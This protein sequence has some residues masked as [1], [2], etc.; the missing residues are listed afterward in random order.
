[1]TILAG[2]PLHPLVVHAAV[3]L[4]PL[5]ALGVVLIAVF[6]KLRRHYSTL[7][8]LLSG[9][10]LL[11]MPIAS[12]TGEDL[13]RYVD[14]TQAMKDHVAMGESGSVAAVAVLVAAC[15]LWWMER[16][17]RRSR[18]TLGKFIV[19]MSVL[20]AIAATAQIV[21]IGHSGATS[22]WAKESV[23]QPHTGWGGEGE[24]GE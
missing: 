7:V 3:V 20:V 11:V 22:A 23:A 5:A 21:R 13:T 4:L 8:V 19:V 16:R 9:A 2:L 15:L 14:H 1:M 12:K 17:A 24:F 18:G 6:P 10:A